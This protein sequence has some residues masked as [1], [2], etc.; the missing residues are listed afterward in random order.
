MCGICGIVGLIKIQNLHQKQD[1]YLNKRCS[2][3]YNERGRQDRAVTQARKPGI[4]E[5]EFEER[6][7]FLSTE[8]L[9]GYH[10]VRMDLLDD[11]STN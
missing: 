10:S 8:V 1:F 6:C 11:S 4:E 5:T 2:I 9:K 7:R 3:I